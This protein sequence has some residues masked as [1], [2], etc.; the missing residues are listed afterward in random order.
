MKHTQKPIPTANHIHDNNGSKLT[1]DY[2]LKI[3]NK[4]WNQVLSNEFG[5]LT[6]SNYNNVR[7]TDTMDFIH[8]SEIPHNEIIT[9]AS[10][11]CDH[12]P[13]K[14]EIWRTRLVI[15]GDK[16]PCYDDADSP[17]TNLIET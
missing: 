10:F 14:P 12:R 16:P 9:Y 15:G 17:A 3:D 4:K 2:L 8:P 6:Q 13:L 11:V 7:Y 1:Q 5:R